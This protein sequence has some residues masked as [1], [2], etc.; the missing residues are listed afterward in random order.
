MRYNFPEALD[1][2][3]MHCTSDIF[4]L[5]EKDNLVGLYVEDDGYYF[6]NCVFHKQF[7]QSLDTVSNLFVQ[8]W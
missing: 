2:N 1:K 4:G 5:Y 6:L 7:A 8:N 3:D